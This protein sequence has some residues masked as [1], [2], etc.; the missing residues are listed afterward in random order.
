MNDSM[1]NTIKRINVDM[2]VSKATE[3]TDKKKQINMVKD[4]KKRIITSQECWNFTEEELAVENQV[5]YILQKSITG[6][7]TK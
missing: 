3:K 6:N 2:S 7:P 5:K 1:E 4:P